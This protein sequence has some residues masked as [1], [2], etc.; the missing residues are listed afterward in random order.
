MAE[1]VGVI[2]AGVAFAEVVVKISKHVFTLKHMWEDFK[3]IPENV[4]LLIGD[5]ELLSRVLQEME[6]DINRPN[7]E[8][9]CLTDGIGSLILTTCRGALDVLSLS[10]EE[11][12]QELKAAKRIKRAVVKAKLVL[13]KDFWSKTEKRLSR[14]VWMLGVAQQHWILSLAK[15]QNRPISTNLPLPQ[16]E[17]LVEGNEA[18]L[19]GRTDQ[20]DILN[21]QRVT[22]SSD[23]LDENRRRRMAEQHLGCTLFGS[24]GIDSTRSVPGHGGAYGRYYF[25]F[26][27]P[28]WLT[29][30]SW[31]I[32]YSI[33]SFGFN[34][35]LRTH[36]VIPDDSLVIHRI[37]LGDVE[38]ILE[39]FDKRLASPFDIN[40]QGDS[41]LNIAM[42]L[43]QAEVM[44]TLIQMGLDFGTCFDPKS[45]SLVFASLSAR[46]RGDKWVFAQR[47]HEL[48]IS[49]NAYDEYTD[50]WLLPAHSFWKGE[51]A[52][53]QDITPGLARAFLESSP[54]ALKLFLPHLRPGHYLLPAIDRL[55]LVMRF[56]TNAGCLRYLL[57]E[58][59]K[60]KKEDIQALED[61]E[62]PLLKFI[63]AEYGDG[64]H[65]RKVA[66]DVQTWRQLARDIIEVTPFLHSRIGEK[67][68]QNTTAAW[69]IY[70]G[71]PLNA[72]IRSNDSCLCLDCGYEMTLSRWRRETERAL[73]RWLEDLQ[74]SGVDLDEYGKEEDRIFMETDWI[75]SL[76]Y[77]FT[78]GVYNDGGCRLASFTYGSE[79]GDWKFEWELER[80][81]LTGEFWEMIENPTLNM[82]GAWVD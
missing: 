76:R 59:G 81:E 14:V 2:A 50:E 60:V 67:A 71:T 41:L 16:T 82:V 74:K 12:F 58:D 36:F 8:G 22:Q 43:A 75:R 78:N 34:I 49:K 32:L 72:V 28:N 57:W 7:L 10:V 68:I 69:F 61:I 31:N 38:G 15:S 80:D 46:V 62:F 47:A 65:S 35:N 26:K 33:S 29:R 9:V 6:A 37:K 27:P 55:H 48:A 53:A 5:I 13:M 11:I 18:G 1:A 19:V 24:V 70:P 66:S 64:K 77:C 4:R 30:K 51:A 3:E 79:P 52:P 44:S 54:D 73:K 56:P 17:L 20:E 25:Q 40:E 21:H 23:P 39:L 42:R 45:A 63:A